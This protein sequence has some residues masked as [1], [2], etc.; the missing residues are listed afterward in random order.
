MLWGTLDD[1]VGRAAPGVWIPQ[2]PDG[3]PLVDTGVIADVLL[4]YPDLRMS[5]DE[6]LEL[7]REVHGDW[8]DGQVFLKGGEGDRHQDVLGFLMATTHCWLDEHDVGH[9][10]FNFQMRC[11]PG[12]PGR[13]VDYLFL[14][15]EHHRERV[16]HTFVDGPADV[17]FEIVSESTRQK[18]WV[19]KRAEYATGGVPE[20]WI[21]DP[22]QNRA[23][24]CRLTAGGLYETASDG[25][26]GRLESEVIPGLWFTT[27]WLAGARCPRIDQVLDEWGLWLS[28]RRRMDV[29]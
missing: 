29:S 12:F 6:F 2:T 22:V 9:T 23:E 18:D 15:H 19:E 16:R 10:L 25:S 13:E 8:I 20:Y 3:V 14:T 27:E 4:L 5:Y 24:I 17:V 21:I 1:C 11:G 26:S 28:P 7:P